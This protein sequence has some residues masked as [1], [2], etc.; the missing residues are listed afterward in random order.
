MSA[1]LPAADLAGLPGLPASTTGVRSRLAAVG[2]RARK[3]SRGKGLEYAVEDLPAETRTAL[4]T[5]AQAS[6]AT[7][8]ARL[9]TPVGALTDRQREVAA[10]RIAV[11]AL[12]DALRAERGLTTRAAFDALAEQS[13]AGELRAD[14]AAL[15]ADAN[16]RGA[17]AAKV[18]R[19]TL[20]RWQREAD[21]ARAAGADPL[22]ALAPSPCTPA[23]PMP[24]WLAGVMSC[25]GRPSKPT[26]AA[27]YRE[28]L[29]TLPQPERDTAPSLRS[30]QRAVEA[31]PVEVRE[32][33][34]MGARARRSVQPFVRRTTDGLWPMDV[35]TVDGHACKNYVLR[36][37]SH[38]RIRP[39]VTT[40]LDIATRRIVG[41]SVWWAESQYAIW[42]ALRSMVLDPAR[43]LADS[44]NGVG[45]IQ[46]SDR[47][48]YRGAEH[49]AVLARLGTVPM[50]SIAYRAQARGAIERLNSSVWIP[51][52]KTQPTYCGDDCDQEIFK[53][54][55]AA[56]DAGD[57][58]AILDWT[59]WLAEC[60]RAI[61][62]Y[63]A[64]P[65]SSLRR[66]RDT[67]SPDQAWQI[68]LDDG[69]QPTLLQGDDLHDL[70]PA[71]MRGA[72]PARR[73][74]RGEVSLPWGRY[75]HDDLRHWHGRDVRVHYDPADGARVWCCRPDGRL[76]CVAERDA[77]ARPYM[78]ASQIEHARAQ[79]EAARVQRLERRIEI[80]QHE[81]TPVLEGERFDLP[82]LVLGTA[83]ALLDLAP[84]TAETEP[85]PAPAA[86]VLPLPDPAADAYL[87]ALDTD[88]ARYEA[89][90]VLRE[91]D[92]DGE[93][94][95]AREQAFL[96]AF[97]RAGYC[98]AME[99]MREAFDA[100]TAGTG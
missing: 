14:Q 7:L 71:A 9:D 13:A 61:R 73:V 60:E 85:E 34:R 58:N 35:V 37:D 97:S 44:P 79:R 57:R 84:L 32:Y 88:P 5:R 68:A 74:S 69:W 27:A 42:L 22:V 64:R 33:A 99:E 52:A 48:A 75:A 28:W 18:T 40:Y 76:I 87:D 3:R 91:R 1:Y 26:V 93:L 100:Q 19:A 59:D 47:G 90:R 95:T 80:A 78:P 31:L 72:Q 4:A 41:Y 23:E 82:D 25:Y 56:A 54:N 94:L 6:V 70:L 86:R 62:A 8:P 2:A 65:H 89:W 77:N 46:Y 10:A 55:L 16:A 81:E 49:K 29:D 66:G 21:N 24:A 67:L 50:Y 92:A 17:G 12:A 63:N 43:G 39:E 53:R 15:V 30:V 98:R 38:R 83:G 20:Y 96:A 11:L 36:P 51:L 45:A